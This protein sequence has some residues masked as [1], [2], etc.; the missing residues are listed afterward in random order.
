VLTSEYEA[1]GCQ[2]LFAS[3][4]GDMDIKGHAA[5]G[6]AQ[7]LSQLPAQPRR[8]ILTCGP[9]PMMQAVAEIAAAEQISCQV[10]LEERMACGIGICLVCICKTKS[11]SADGKD[12]LTHA[13]CCVDGPVFQAEEVIW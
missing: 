7:L 11:R 4:E 1:A 3:D 12:Q 5:Q 10:S 13:R 8:A 2:V 9:K 6:L